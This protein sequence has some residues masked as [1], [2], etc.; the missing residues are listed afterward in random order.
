MEA[1]MPDGMNGDIL[2]WL[3]NFLGGIALAAFGFLWK[4]MNGIER[5]LRQE[6]KD[7]RAEIKAASEASSAARDKQ[8]V[9]LEGVR[10]DVSDFKD[11][12]LRTAATKEDLRDMERRLIENLRRQDK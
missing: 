3:L 10:K 12:M 8:W 7:L 9:A 5:D 6:V 4:R 11:S 2:R 1:A